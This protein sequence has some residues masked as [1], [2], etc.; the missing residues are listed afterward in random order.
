MDS[1]NVVIITSYPKRG[2]IHA[3][4]T[5][6]VAS[7]TKQ[8]LTV[9]QQVEPDRKL[10][11]W[12]EQWSTQQE[13]YVEDKIRVKRCWH[14]GNFWSI[15]QILEEVLKTPTKTVMVSF[16]AY[17]FGNLWLAG[18]AVL[19]LIGARMRGKR[20]IILLHQVVGDF[21]DIEKNKWKAS[22]QNH[23][24]R[25]FYQAIL[26]ASTKVVVFESALKDK[27]GTNKKIV[28]IPH[29]IPQVTPI[30]QTQAKQQ[31]GWKANRKYA[32]CFGYIAP[33]KG[34]DQLVKD[35]PKEGD[36]KLVIGGGI[37]PNH[38]Q[39]AEIIQFVDQVEKLADE[40]EVKVTGFIKEELIPVYFSACD[41]VILPYPA[42]ISSS[43]PM[44]LAIAYGKPILMNQALEKYQQTPDFNQALKQA[45]MKMSDLIYSVSPDSL[46]LAL[47]NLPI[48]QS[49]IDNYLKIIR[50]ARRPNRVVERL[51][52]LIQ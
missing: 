2:E 41:V 17:M 13:S 18:W 27:L 49:K 10:E 48:N 38:V 45:G 35:W 21:K 22:W 40:R 11:V 30:D 5:V 12:A 34:I 9:W 44:A 33:Y 8:L 43:G 47:H 29:L 50:E 1:R 15:T 24:K 19:G 39:D 3:P 4:E 42:F 31:L 37:N 51:I 6:G 26:W 28:V 52:N 16:E 20:I 25:I 46:T 32:L 7:Y 23:L 36:F 14:R